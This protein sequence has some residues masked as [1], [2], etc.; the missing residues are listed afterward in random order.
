MLYEHLS[1]ICMLS[2]S[3]VKGKMFLKLTITVDV[4]IFFTVCHLMSREGYRSCNSSDLYM[5]DT[6][7]L[8]VK[9]IL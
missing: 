6:V 4:N 9:P 5:F 7:Y 2:L 8:K 3:S 1:C